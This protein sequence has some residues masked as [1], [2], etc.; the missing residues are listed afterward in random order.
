MSSVLTFSQVPQYLASLAD[1]KIRHLC[2][3]T[4]DERLMDYQRTER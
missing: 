4:G 1:I 2:C 3:G